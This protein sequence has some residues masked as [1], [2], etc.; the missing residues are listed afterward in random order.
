MLQGSS[1][2][3]LMQWPAAGERRSLPAF[4]FDHTLRLAPSEA[5]QEGQQTP[6][7]PPSGNKKVQS[8]TWADAP[9]HFVFKSCF[10]D[11]YELLLGPQY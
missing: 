4:V 2:A 10:S 5:Q 3:Y 11:L 6:Q 7:G 1:L 9:K 8:Q